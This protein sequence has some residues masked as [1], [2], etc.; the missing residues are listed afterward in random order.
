MPWR[1]EAGPQGLAC[2]IEDDIL[3]ACNGIGDTT[4]DEWAVIQGYIVPS[5]PY[6]A[7]CRDGLWRTVANDGTEFPLPVFENCTDAWRHV[8]GCAGLPI[9]RRSLRRR[10]HRA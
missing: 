2:R 3:R 9:R 10:R 5:R 6:R 4:A 7:V 1:T 8:T